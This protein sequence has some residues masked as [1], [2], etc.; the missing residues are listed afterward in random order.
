MVSSE[1]SMEFGQ[2]ANFI[3]AADL[4]WVAC[5]MGLAYVLR[6]GW[7]WNGPPGHSAAISR[8]LCWRRYLYGSC[9]PHGSSWTGSCSGWRFSS[10]VSQL[11]LAVSLLIVTLL[12]C[13]YLLRLYVSRLML[14][15]FCLLLFLGLST[16]PIRC[17]FRLPIPIS[18]RCRTQ[19]RHCRQRIFSSRDGR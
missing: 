11:L 17:V 4:T 1:S 3:S 15:Y 6:Y 19:S 14:G 2:S 8:P 9:S 7:V 5:A 12:V 18:K 10:V 13:G 16:N